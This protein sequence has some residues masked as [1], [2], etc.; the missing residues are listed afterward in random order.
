MNTVY[1]SK[2]DFM[3]IFLLKTKDSEKTVT[4]KIHENLFIYIHLFD[5]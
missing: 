2:A 5:I 3:S 4:C 1:F